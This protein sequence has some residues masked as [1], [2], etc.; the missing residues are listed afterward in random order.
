MVRVMFVSPILLDLR[1]IS[2][3]KRLASLPSRFCSL[4]GCFVVAQSPKMGC[5]DPGDSM[6]Y[7]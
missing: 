1:L 5:I 6:Q 4:R 3:N 2:V 7:M